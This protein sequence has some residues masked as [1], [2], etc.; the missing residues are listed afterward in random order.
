MV[1]FREYV[2]ADR[3]EPLRQ[4]DVLEAVDA[5]ASPWDRLLFVVTADC[6]LAH[7]KHNGRVTCVP[8]LDQ[9]EYLRIFAVPKVASKIETQLYDELTQLLTRSGAGGISLERAR[10]W[11]LEAAN[12]QIIEALR[13][14]NTSGESEAK[15]LGAIRRINQPVGRVED[16]IANALEAQSTVAHPPKPKNARRRVTDSLRECYRNPP[17]DALFISSVAPGRES[18]YFAY[19]R[20]IEQVMESDIATGPMR[21]QATHRRIARLSDRYAHALVQ[22]FALV[23]MP[24]GLPPEYEEMRD[25]YAESIGL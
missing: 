21:R 19:L 17:G 6:D 10:E 8:L 20:H 2:D 11:V 7:R 23:F 5:N 18:G 1:S 24:V 4:G 13:S 9:E 15:L 14:D 3:A 25:L 12:D 16:F 22:R